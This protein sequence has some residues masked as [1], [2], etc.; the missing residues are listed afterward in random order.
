MAFYDKFPYTNFQE[1]NLDTI[2]QK[3]GDID[4]SIERAEEATAD[5]VA[6]AAA[7]ASQAATSASQATASA[8]QAATS[9]A[10]SA[11]SAT[12][13]AGSASNAEETA[14]HFRDAEQQININTERINNIL[15]TGTPTE[16]NAELIDIRV[17][18]D[19]VS[20]T[21]AGQAVRAQYNELAT[22]VKNFPAGAIRTTV[23]TL[24]GT[25][26]AN[27]AWDTG[28]PT[29]PVP[30]NNYNFTTYDVT[31][32]KGVIL[33]TGAS[34]GNP[35]P[36]IAFYDSSNNLLSKDGIAGNTRHT[37][38]AVIVPATA[39]KAVVNGANETGYAGKID[40]FTGKTQERVN[41]EALR[42]FGTDINQG[43]VQNHPEYSS[44]RNWHGDRIYNLGASAHTVVTDLPA[45]FTTYGSVIKMNGYFDS[46]MAVSQRGYSTYICM[47]ADSAWFGFDTGS[48]IVWHSLATS[49]A[50]MILFIGDSYAQGYSHDGTNP[51]WINYLAGYLGL[52]SAEYVLADN[53]G[54]SFTNTSNSY[55]NL[56]NNAETRAYTDIIVCGGFNDYPYTQTEIESAIST[57]VNRAHSLYPNAKVHVACVGWIK[58]GSGSG[59]LSDWNTIRTNIENRVIPAYHNAS[60]YNAAYM[61][62][63]EFAL[64]D[65]NLTPSDGY[66]PS[67]EG[68]QAIAS[69]LANAFLTGSAPMPYRRTYRQ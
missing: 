44:L 49:E 40:Y 8:S 27:R 25:V 58:E 60:K 68:N 29:V 9:A 41:V 28:A 4:R 19:G 53:G 63:V 61:N 32:I 7:S 48:G 5:N 20:Y 3:I 11:Q 65:S 67:A 38:R 24:S 35:Y 31:N 37:N 12:A 66:H 16:G 1:L 22:T 15:V 43:Y 10:A 13:A 46:D 26:T 39:T 57:F 47:G 23:N 50:K 14:S 55:I 18:G 69:A 21:S 62:N 30:G 33:V 64:N 59:A 17:G 2:V 54:A 34:W 6:Q 45:D 42:P 51:G 52:S 56:L 36:L